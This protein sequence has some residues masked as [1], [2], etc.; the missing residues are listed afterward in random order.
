MERRSKTEET[1]KWMFIVKKT[2]AAA[3]KKILDNKLQEL[4]QTIIPNELKFA[5]FPTPKR[6]FNKETRA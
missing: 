6:I 3:A 5:Q 4:Y 1:G 2:N